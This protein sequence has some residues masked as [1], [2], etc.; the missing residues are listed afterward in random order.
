MIK[1]KSKREGWGLGDRG[2]DQ[3]G[4]HRHM[5]NIKGNYIKERGQVVRQQPHIKR[6]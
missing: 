5:D 2:R 3:L 1:I 6:G 4:R